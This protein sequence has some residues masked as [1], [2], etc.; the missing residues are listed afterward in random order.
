MDKLRIARLRRDAARG[1]LADVFS[2]P[3]R[4]TEEELRLLGFSESMIE[5]F[6]RPFLAGV[7]LDREL[8]TSCRMLYFVFRMFSHGDTALPARGM[9]AISDQL[10]SKLPADAI[11]CNAAVTSLDDE[12][13]QLKSGESISYRRLL[14][15]GEQT[16]ASKLIPELSTSRLPRSVSCVYFSA[17]EPP[18]RDRMLVL[19]G[20]GSGLVNNLCV[21]SQINSGYAPPGQSLVSATV[22]NAEVDV[23]SLHHGVRDHLRQWFGKV[24]DTW[25]HLRTYRIPN[26]LPN[27]STPAFDPPVHPPRLSRRMFVCGD[28]RSNG[29]IN[30]A[31][32][33]GRIAA[34]E[35]L[36][37][38]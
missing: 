38:L 9:G 36:K 35:I 29:S 33:S 25:T 32:Q 12:R 23:D 24:V 8:Q 11:R 3:D 19:N 20:T 6:L 13:V 26:A 2:R 28:Y 21:P 1:D 4:S 10:A 18:V 34:E 30:G 14:M 5:G 16:E 15:A 37:E 17:T 27:Q 7:F 31:L 22:L